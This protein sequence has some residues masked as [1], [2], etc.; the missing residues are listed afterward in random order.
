[1]TILDLFL[2]FCNS[3]LSFKVFNISLLNYLIIFTSII[4]IFKI[5]Q[6]IGNSHVSRKEKK[7]KKG[8]DKE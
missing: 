4:F 5:I 6:I 8:S 7:D 3:I 1:M 2:E